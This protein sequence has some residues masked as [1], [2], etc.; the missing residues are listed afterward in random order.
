MG[1]H[2]VF[3][4]GVPAQPSCRCYSYRA[5]SAP[6]KPAP[7]R[8]KQRLKPAQ[9][10][11][12]GSRLRHHGN[13]T[14][15]PKLMLCWHANWELLR[16]YVP[17]S[18]FSAH[19]QLGFD[20]ARA[21]FVADSIPHTPSSHHQAQ[22][23]RLSIPRIYQTRERRQIHITTPVCYPDAHQPLSC[24]RL[25]PVERNEGEEKERKKAHAQAQRPLPTKSP[26]RQDKE[27][28]PYQTKRKREAKRQRQTNLRRCLG[29]NSPAAR[30]LSRHNEFRSQVPMQ[31]ASYHVPSSLLAFPCQ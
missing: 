13:I 31:H 27:K 23:L 4:T 7:P 26:K 15:W 29:Q 10:C 14:T 17:P 3:V 5:L 24:H 16:R 2:G 21:T 18:F 11:Y 22:K 8:C 19:S 30:R 1:R 28:N 20:T 25:S 9:R 6:M 12:C